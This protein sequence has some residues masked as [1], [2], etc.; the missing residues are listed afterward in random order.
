L[1]PA[2]VF[3]QA[4][5]AF[6]N[7]QLDTAERNFKKFLRSE[8][9][10]FG[11]LNLYAALLLQQ[12]RFAEAEPLLRKS[13]TIN[14][15]SD[16]T[17]YNFG[18]ALKSLN[19]PH[20]A[21]DA[22]TKA[23]S[24]QPDIAES[25]NNLGTVYNDLRRYDDAI[26][27]FDRA[28]RLSERYADAFYNKGKSLSALGENDAA[29]NAF[30]HALRIKPNSWKA[31]FAIGN[32]HSDQSSHERAIEAYE[33]ALRLNP[34]SYEAWVAKAFP[35]LSMR[36]F[37]E[38]V[39]ACQKALSFKPDLA[40][41]KSLRLVCR[42][43][44]CDWSRYEDEV[45]D[46]FHDIETKHA[47]V[48]LSLALP[49]AAAFQLTGARNFFKTTTLQDVVP[50]PAVRLRNSGYKI[51]VGY[52]SSDL[53][54]HPVAQ[55]L[56]G[57]IEHHDREKFEVL[58]ISLSCESTSEMGQR[59][60]AAFDQ[61]HDVSSKTDTE[62]AKLIR[63]LE[64]DIVVDLNGHT[65]GMRLGILA[66]CT[67]PIRVSYLGFAGTM[68]NPHRDYIIADRVV[69]PEDHQ[70][71]FSE[72]V[73]SLPEA[74][75]PAD[76]KRIISKKTPIREDFNLPENG[77]VFCAFNNAYKITPPI[78]DV[79]MRLLKQIDGS[80]LWLSS[81]SETARTNLRREAEQRGVSPERLIFSERVEK[82]EDHL[83]RHRLADLFLDTIYYN[84]HTTASDA[85]WA[86]L[87]VLTCEGE[88]FASRVA[89]SLLR[90]VGLPELVTTSLDEYEAL[91]LKL[92][93]EPAL[94]A[95][96]KAKLAENRLTAP[97]FD[98]ERYTRHLEAAYITMW[99]RSQ[100]GE[101]PA[102]F[103][104]EALPRS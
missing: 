80:V 43:Y 6:Q 25:W 95:S 30:D 47:G 4:L 19:K 73:V 103:E 65:Q 84:A 83:A 78:F 11:A 38:A 45:R 66:R 69:I 21:L 104:V 99:E 26:A 15:Q 90:A 16:K 50:A 40:N 37:E 52:L 28:I 14:A 49:A 36:R 92:A 24:I 17:F 48:I 59:I 39:A 71:H 98:T 10:H 42:G 54:D 100:R 35:L 5:I 76:G 91:A 9:K 51:K 102:S 41:A 61:F 60:K 58:A 96:I 70:I 72:R 56:A 75:M 85:L 33:F 68:G 27:S 44:I 1:Q 57:V 63:D 18:L 101:P 62:V 13:I 79:W 89:S 82:Q 77:M 87:P 31:W 74:F 7:G 81:L 29:L 53:R 23:I 97:L 2:F 34:E 20:E 94:L 46:L 8:P 67:A 22:F 55:V 32:V 3:N 64:L 88:T 86:G 12:E 93:R